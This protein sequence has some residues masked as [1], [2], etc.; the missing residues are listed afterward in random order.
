MPGHQLT[1]FCKGCAN[2]ASCTELCEKLEKL[3]PEKISLHKE[4]KRRKARLIDQFR[5][6]DRGAI[7]R[8]DSELGAEWGTNPP[9]APDLTVDDYNFLGEI[10]NQ[11]I[12]N[13]KQRGRFKKFL[14]CTRMT[15][16]A[17]LAGCSK[18]NIHKLFKKICNEIQKEIKG[19]EALSHINTPHKVKR[20]YKDLKPDTN[21]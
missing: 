19:G 20:K 2:F 13:R 21:P 12:P 6:V 17:G 11:C 3:L 9:D 10:I 5:K 1:D 18:Q 7:F 14:E 16:I 8:A 15:E 4:R